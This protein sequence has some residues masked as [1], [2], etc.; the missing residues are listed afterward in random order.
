[1][2]KDITGLFCF[3]DD[4]V[5]AVKLCE[6]RYFLGDSSRKPTRELSLDMTKIMTIILLYYRSDLKNFKQ[7]YCLYLP[8]Y[9]AEL[10]K[11]LSYNRF[12]EI[13]K[14]ALPYL[15]CLMRYLCS[16]SDE[17]GIGYIDST[18][19]AV[20]SNKRTSNHKVFKD[21]AK[22]GKTTKGWFFGLKLHLLTNEKGEIMNFEFT[23]GNVDD[24]DPVPNLTKNIKGL[25]FGDKGYIKKE[26]FEEL[27]AN[28][29]KLVTGLK[30][31]MKQK[32][33]EWR[34]S[35]LLSKR[36]VIESVFNIM[37]NHFELEHTRHRSIPNACV[38]FLGVLIS[39]CFK[40]SKPSIKYHNLIPN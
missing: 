23:S 7:Y 31:N 34:D 39:Y 25:L 18:S 9:K 8:Q 20:C 17:T 22:L 10:G 35:Y 6:E 14:R 15:E 33:M 2:K 1:M 26:L 27:F 21:I 12:I 16:L 36:S 3:V 19:I 38:D 4:F 11:L 5:K 24:R 28:G 30:K 13:E 29:L 40:K 37:K 32:L